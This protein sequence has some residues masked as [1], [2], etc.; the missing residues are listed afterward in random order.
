L[1]EI[2][3]KA[4]GRELSAFDPY[5]PVEPFAIERSLRVAIDNSI[6]LSKQFFTLMDHL[7]LQFFQLGILNH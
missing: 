2:E 3:P 7:R 1:T 5:D 6:T 4:E